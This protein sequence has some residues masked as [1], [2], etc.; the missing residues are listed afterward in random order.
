MKKSKIK[1]YSKKSL[2]YSHPFQNHFM[3]L[4]A[5]R[6]TWGVLAPSPRT[7]IVSEKAWVLILVYKE[8]FIY[9]KRA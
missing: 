1:I 4:G 2:I 7:I 9:Y 3:V 5:L 6:S 8:I